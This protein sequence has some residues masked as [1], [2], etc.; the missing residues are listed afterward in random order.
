[1][2]CPNA[3]SAGEKITCKITAN[4]DAD[5][6]EIKGNF[7]NEGLGSLAFDKNSKLNFTQSDSNGFRISEEGSILSKTGSNNFEIG[8]VSAT[9]PGNATEG[10]SFKI[11]INN[12]TANG[13]LTYATI[14]S[15]IHIKS[16]DNTLKSLSVGN[17]PLSPVFNSSTT[18]YKIVLDNSSALN[19]IL[20]SYC[21]IP[22]KN[23]TTSL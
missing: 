19:L 17:Y 2:S 7:S 4:V 21:I 10:N 3:A 9:I 20:E 22:I 18:S 1:M 16:S 23:P 12:I 6:N 14:T 5:I 11:T 13:N 15:T 8:S